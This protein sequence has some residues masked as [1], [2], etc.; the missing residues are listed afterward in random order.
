ML[1]RID[2]ATNMDVSLVNVLR[3]DAFADGYVHRW[4][5]PETTLAQVIAGRI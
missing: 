3:S 2:L 4:T 5:I 1:S